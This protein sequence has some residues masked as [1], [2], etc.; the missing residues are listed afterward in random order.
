L[1]S[2]SGE[3]QSQSVLLVQNFFLGPKPQPPAGAVQIF[4]AAAAVFT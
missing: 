1:A 3:P 4:Q 2:F